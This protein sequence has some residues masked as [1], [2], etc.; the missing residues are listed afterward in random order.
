M[1]G[2]RGKLCRSRQNS[3]AGAL[4]ALGA[5]YGVQ[6][7]EGDEPS[8]AQFEAAKA[9]LQGGKPKKKSKKSAK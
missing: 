9:R 2:C 8:D 1:R 7:D 5:K 6:L 3:H 4:A